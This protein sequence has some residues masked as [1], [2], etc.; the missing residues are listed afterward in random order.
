M[1]AE[2][3]GPGCGVTHVGSIALV[4]CWPGMCGL[5]CIV[6]DLGQRS[7][8][9]VSKHCAMLFAPHRMS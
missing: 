8:Q 9:V 3:L 2:G 6:A 5:P 1:G 4:D 7:G